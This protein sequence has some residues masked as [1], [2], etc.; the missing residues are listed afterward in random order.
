LSHRLCAVFKASLDKVSYYEHDK[1]GLKERYAIDEKTHSELH[2][3]I[4]QIKQ[5]IQY[6]FEKN[7]E[8]SKDELTIENECE[9]G[10][11]NKKT[12]DTYVLQYLITKQEYGGVLE[13][14]KNEYYITIV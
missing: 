4:D 8:V 12:T 5:A 1:H 14:L 6:E 7:Y 9:Y 2:R 13:R 11:E 10:T 3:R